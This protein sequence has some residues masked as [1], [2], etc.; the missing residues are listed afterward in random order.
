MYYLAM[1][2]GDKGEGAEWVDAQKVAYLDVVTCLSLVTPKIAATVLKKT[3]VQKPHPPIVTTL[4]PA[5]E[6]E[7]GVE[8]RLLK[9]TFFH[10]Y[11]CFFSIGDCDPEL[12]PGAVHPGAGP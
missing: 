9:K 1:R 11:K 2:I 5:P 6:T 10:S 12:V 7:E 4:Q 3:G 8:V